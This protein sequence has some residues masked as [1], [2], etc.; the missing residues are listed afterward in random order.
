MLSL[1]ISSPCSQDAH[2]LRHANKT[3]PS[4][5]G[6]RK[7]QTSG[8]PQSITSV[9][10]IPHTYMLA[11]SGSGDTTVKL[12][13]M[14]KACSP[15]TSLHAGPSS[16]TLTPPAIRP[17]GIPPCSSPGA[18]SLVT[19]SFS[20]RGSGPFGVTCMAASHQGQYHVVSSDHFHKERFAYHVESSSF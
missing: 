13:D 9:V 11:S 10:F 20:C 8:L 17:P 6:G 7:D 1:R 18:P 5:R 16:V 12:W 2:S 3:P 14:R 15:I 4:G 19:A